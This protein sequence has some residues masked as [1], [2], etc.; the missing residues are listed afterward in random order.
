MSFGQ[1]ARVLTD[2]EEIELW[3]TILDHQN[4]TFI[5]SGRG[6]RPGIPFSYRISRNIDV[7]PGAEMYVSTRSK[8]ITRATI[9]LAY[10]KVKMMGFMVPG[11]KAIGVHGDSYIFAVFKGLGVI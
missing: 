10:Q 5:T 6:S 2:P 8:S 3:D 4:E 1:H 7:S 11:P 9:M